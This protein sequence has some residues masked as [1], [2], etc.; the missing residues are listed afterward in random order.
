MGYAI[1]DKNILKSLYDIGVI[2]NVKPPSIRGVKV[3]NTSNRRNSKNRN[4]DL[5]LDKIQ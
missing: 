3:D 2:D 1:L 5:S 4:L